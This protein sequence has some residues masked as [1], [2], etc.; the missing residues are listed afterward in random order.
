[1]FFLAFVLCLLI[2]PP[3]HAK[4][5]ACSFGDNGAL[6]TEEQAKIY[7]LHKRNEIFRKA[8]TNCDGKLDQEEMQRFSHAA[9]HDPQ[10]ILDVH[11]AERLRQAGQPMRVDAADVA[12]NAGK[13]GTVSNLNL[14]KG[15]TFLLR[16]SYKDVS[17]FSA[18][19]EAKDASGAAFGWNRDGEASNRAWSAKGVVAVPYLWRNPGSVEGPYL[20]GYAFAPSISFNRVTNSNTKLAS[21]DIDIL[22]F[23]ISNEVAIGN[24]LGGTQY[25]R[26]RGSL[27]S[28]FDGDDKS[29]ALV[30]EWQPFITPLGLSVPQPI[31]TT[32]ATFTFEPVL[33]A[34]Y[35]RNLGNSTDPLFASDDD[36][37]RSGPMATLS[38]SPE[39]W[40]GV[41]QWARAFR[42][43]SSY[44]Y[45]HDFSNSDNYTLWS[46]E[47]FMNL[48]DE[49][50]LA[51]KF[52]YDKGKLEE[53]AQKID[54][55]K[56]G[57]AA[58]W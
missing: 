33:R 36:V 13:K 35:A 23:G 9:E 52:N 44:G 43:S 31:G 15:W 6:M 41:P 56:V 24:F 8:D 3:A 12:P 21:K 39:K 2:V 27:L 16:D 45:L 20:A 53:T 5:P 58:K 30:G 7:F 4:A 14:P 29:V 42:L 47:I 51:L 55:A 48:D 28:N 1:M 38:I 46:S 40:D 32:N 17:I 19:K 10:F 50:H 49:G 22:S 57:L 37:F 25:F 54:L 34:E 18:P 26:L 11:D